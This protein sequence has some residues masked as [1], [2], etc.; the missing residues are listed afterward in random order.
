MVPPYRVPMSNPPTPPEMECL[1]F[2]FADFDVLFRKGYSELSFS[3]QKVD[4]PSDPERCEG[5]IDAL[6][7]GPQTAMNTANSYLGGKTPQELLESGKEMLDDKLAKA[8]ESV[9]GGGNDADD[10][11]DVVIEEL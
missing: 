2:K 10:K 1:G 8:R 7:S 4:E 6:R 5:F 3:Y 9:I 11:D